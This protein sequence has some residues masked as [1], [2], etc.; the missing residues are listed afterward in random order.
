MADSEAVIREQIQRGGDLSIP[1]DARPPMSPGMDQYGGGRVTCRDNQAIT[2][3]AK[4]DVGRDETDLRLPPGAFVTSRTAPIQV[5]RGESQ[6]SPV[7]VLEH[8]G[9]EGKATSAD[10]RSPTFAERPAP[11]DNDHVG[12]ASAGVYT[13][14]YESHASAR[15][16]D[17]PTRSPHGVG[18]QPPPPM[19]DP[20]VDVTPPPVQP[21]P[22]EYAPATEQPVQQPTPPIAAAAAPPK[23]SK[24]RVVLSSAGM[25]RINAKVHEIAVSDSLV[26][27]GFIDDDN[28]VIVEPPFCDDLEVRYEDQVYPCAYRG[29]TFEMTIPG[30]QGVPMLMVVLVR[31]D[32]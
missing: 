4:A 29:M 15:L 20:P 5:I 26:V 3:Q 28:T 6:S 1:L 25:G 12:I 13:E 21:P 18:V 30:Y 7:E 10:T 17:E 8:V 9:G 14:S 32:R 22:E 11:S 19:T 2:P 24:K 27:L 16:A 23:P 31:L